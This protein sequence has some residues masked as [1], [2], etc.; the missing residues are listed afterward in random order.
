MIVSHIDTISAVIFA[1]AMMLYLVPAI[2]EKIPRYR[3]W[4]YYL[5]V[6]LASLGECCVWMFRL[7]WIGI[8]LS[9]VLIMAF[10]YV[11]SH[12]SSPPEDE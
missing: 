10:I 1:M 5:V 8:G 9:A 6:F 11:S 2:R 4:P 12:P 3:N 7:P